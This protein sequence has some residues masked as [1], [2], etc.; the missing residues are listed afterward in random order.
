MSGSLYQLNNISGPL[1]RNW[2]TARVLIGDTLAAGPG[3]FVDTWT[4]GAAHPT[5]SSGI[6]SSGAVLLPSGNVVILP[7]GSSTTPIY[8]YNPTT[9][10]LTAGPV[11]GSGANFIG[12][13]LLPNGTVFCIPDNNPNICIYDPVANTLT[14]VLAHGITPLAGIFTGAALGLDGNVYL[15]GGNS[16]CSNYGLLQCYN[17]G[18]NTL[19]TVATLTGTTG[20][21][22]FNGCATLPNGQILII[23][24]LAPTNFLYNPAT[25]AL[26]NGTASHGTQSKGCMLPDGRYMYCP[27]STASV[28]IYN[29]ALNADTVIAVL[30]GLQGTNYFCASVLM[31]DGQVAFMPRD[32]SNVVIVNP[33]TAAVTVGVA[34]S[35]SSTLDKFRA[36]VPLLTGGILLIPQAAA[37]FGLFTPYSGG[38]VFSVNFLTSRF[39]QK[40]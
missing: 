16:G 22:P 35:N 33:N 2:A 1:L 31:Q 5:V 25:G 37:N 26:T 19:T 10:T 17:V 4:D 30:T 6:L 11:P 32:H 3:T 38:G 20:N 24:Y 21:I 34:T 7:L 40:Q 15:S 39:V 14:P 18:A 28:R 13:L 23:S 27:S 8:I 29:P 36:A 9:N 12:G